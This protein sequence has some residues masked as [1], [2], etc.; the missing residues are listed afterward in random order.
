MDPKKLERPTHQICLSGKGSILL[1]MHSIY[2]AKNL[3][4]VWLNTTTNMSIARMNWI[5]LPLFSL[6]LEIKFCNLLNVFWLSRT[7][8]FRKLNI[9]WLILYLDYKNKLYTRC[10]IWFDFYWNLSFLNI[11]CNKKLMLQ[12]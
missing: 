8:H 6:W 12:S 5:C 1:R 11:I 2:S 10:I 9:Y 3:L 7:Y 4:Y